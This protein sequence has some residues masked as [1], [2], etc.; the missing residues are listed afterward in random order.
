MESP[1]KA[2][3]LLI[4]VLLFAAC[5][6]DGTQNVA[7]PKDG[8]RNR[9]R[10][11]NSSEAV[12]DLQK[13]ENLNN[14]V[15]KETN[16]VEIVDFEGTAGITNEKS[17]SVGAAILRE[18]RVGRHAAY[19]RVVFEFEGKLMPGYRIEYIDK[20]VRACGSGHVVALR[21]DGW[22]EISFQPAMAHTENGEPTIK[23]RERSPD[24]PIIREL[25]LTCDFETEVTWVLGVS[26]PNNYRVLELDDPTRLAIDIKHR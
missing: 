2:F 13:N 14:G 11:V 16:G 10:A 19:D 8:S 21:G 12:G 9:N 15:G 5:R 7:A 25:K 4:C 24:N 18:V 26:S 17:E 22:L 23:E 20:P 6:S 1:K 3:V